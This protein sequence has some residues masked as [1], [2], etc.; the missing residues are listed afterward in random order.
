MAARRKKKSKFK[1]IFIFLAIIIVIGLVF[2]FVVY[3]KAKAKVT[4]AIATKMLEQQIPDGVSSDQVEQAQQ[5]YNSMSEED[6]DTVDNLIDNKLNAGTISDVSGY[7][8]NNDTEGLKE[9]VKDSFSEQ[10][11]QQIKDLYQKYQ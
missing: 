10:E 9:Y 5:I 11:I 4:S 8:K 7:L 6:K 1:A 3:D 2:R